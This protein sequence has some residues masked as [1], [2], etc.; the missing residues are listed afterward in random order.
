MSTPVVESQS[1]L[2]LRRIFV[3]CE[4]MPVVAI[5]FSNGKPWPLFTRHEGLQLCRYIRSLS[6]DKSRNALALV[7]DGRWYR[8][9]RERIYRLK[10]ML[11]Y[12]C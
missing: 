11:W 3:T 7:E 10:S 12:E 8:V 9:R 4:R 6:F 5:A 2:A 1:P